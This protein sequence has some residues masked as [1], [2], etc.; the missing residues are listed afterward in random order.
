MR[1]KNILNGR[2]SYSFPIIIPNGTALSNTISF[3]EY[4]Y[5]IL[6]MP[7][8]W[9]AAN[10]GFQ[11]ASELD[12]TFLPLYD[13]TGAIVEIASPAVD[14]AMR[15]PVEVLAA[16]YV[17]AWSQTGGADTNQG[18]ERALIFDMKS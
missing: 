1:P 9:T 17:K 16:R 18:A 15:V 5:G 12:G 13:D 14:Q 10:I 7:A 8:G 6:H 11:I 3:Y 4:G 2:K